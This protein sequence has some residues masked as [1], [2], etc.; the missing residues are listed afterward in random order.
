MPKQPE[1]KITVNVEGIGEAKEQINE[2]I[3]L[4]EK[5]H[6]II[7]RLNENSAFKIIT[8]SQNILET[9]C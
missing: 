8:E 5:A 6:G 1:M 3:T 2:L 9:P 7:Q 4:L